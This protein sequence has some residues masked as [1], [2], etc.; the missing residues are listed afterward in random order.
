MGFIT[1]ETGNYNG[2]L[3]SAWAGTGMTSRAGLGHADL[4]PSTLVIGAN[5]LADEPPAEPAAERRAH[6]RGVAV[7]KAAR[8]IC[9]RETLCLIRNISAAGLMADIYHPVPAGS[10]VVV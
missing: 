1:V 4:T 6:Q 5:D 9:D 7:L 2:Q 3:R 8:L 10:K